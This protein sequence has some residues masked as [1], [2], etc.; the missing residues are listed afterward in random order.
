MYAMRIFVNNLDAIMKSNSI[1]SYNDLSLLLDVNVNT[2]K[3]WLSENRAISLKRLDKVADTLEVP[4]YL[5][6]KNDLIHCDDNN[7]KANNN[8]SQKIFANNLQQIFINK[9]KTSWNERESLFNGKFSIPTLIAYTRKTDPRVPLLKNLDYM[10][11]CL[12]VEVHLMI[13]ESAFK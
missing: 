11:E 12:G 10:A 5:L 6:I 4:T 13:M 9:S 3:G 1:I 8:N 2:L 7:I